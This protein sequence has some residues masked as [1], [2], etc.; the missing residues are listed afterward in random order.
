[1][2]AE[3]LFGAIAVRFGANGVQKVQPGFRQHG[4]IGES[5]ECGRVHGRA[6]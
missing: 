5:L 3:N 2:T 1:V 6:G 4:L